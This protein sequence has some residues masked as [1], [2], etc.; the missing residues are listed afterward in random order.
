M[1]D[2]DAFLKAGT[3]IRQIAKS[4]RTDDTRPI[5]IL[6]KGDTVDFSM[7]LWVINRMEDLYQHAQQLPG[8]DCK[9][10]P[11]VEQTSRGSS[12]G[13]WLKSE[14]GGASETKK[15]GFAKT[16]I[17]AA[18]AT[19]V[20]V[21]AISL[22]AEDRTLINAIQMGDAS[23]PVWRAIPSAMPAVTP[24]K[25][26]SFKTLGEP[27]AVDLADND[28]FD[29]LRRLQNWT[30]AHRQCDS[31]VYKAAIDT[32]DKFVAGVTVSEKG[33][34]AIVNAALLGDGGFAK[35]PFILRV[36]ID[37]RGGTSITRSNIWY[38]IGL[39]GAA[40]ITSGLKVSFQLSDP[41]LGTSLVT[42]QIRCATRPTS[43]RDVRNMLVTQQSTG[44]NS[45]GDR[46][47]K[48]VTCAYRIG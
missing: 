24:A 37:D 27:S 15:F 28:A 25:T 11:I 1:L 6:A 40:V 16:D 9:K 34:P 12:M 46:Q 23:D 48:L 45:L 18:L 44:P 41:K 29:A 14:D 31:D 42:G 5:L 7:A 38:S 47:E 43:Y 3:A 17:V 33:P 13:S 2:S 39:P 8:N 30:D 35:L 19:E 10:K 26:S 20:S 36:A 22:T 32:I 4:A 21:G